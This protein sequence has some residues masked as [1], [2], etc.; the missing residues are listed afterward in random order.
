[1]SDIRLLKRPHKAVLGSLDS[2]L[3]ESAAGGSERGTIVEYVHARVAQIGKAGDPNTLETERP[4]SRKDSDARTD[5]T[6]RK[7]KPLCS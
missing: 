1:M 3:L 4:L 2:P 7:T 6:H 5:S